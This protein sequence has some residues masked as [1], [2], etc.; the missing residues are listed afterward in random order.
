MR[1]VLIIIGFTAVSSVLLAA[2]VFQRESAELLWQQNA[3]IENIIKMFNYSLSKYLSQIA[4]ICESSELSCQEKI[5]EINRLLHLPA[6]EL[7]EG[8]RI[9]LGYYLSD[10]GEHVVLGSKKNRDIPVIIPEPGGILQLQTQP[11]EPSGGS[12]YSAPRCG[13]I[14]QVSP[15]YWGDRE[16]GQVFASF[17]ANTFTAR[18]I[19]SFP[20]LLIKVLLL[21][22][23][24]FSAVF[25]IT[26]TCR[27]YID[28]LTKNLKT[29][30]K[31]C[32]QWDGFPEINQN[33]PI[34]FSL[35]C[36]KYLQLA[37]QNWKLTRELSTSLNMA[38]MGEMIRAM[39]HDIRNLLA[40]I[41]ASA[42]IGKITKDSLKQAVMLENIIT[43]GD[44]IEDFLNR[45]L[46]LSRYSRDIKEEIELQEICNALLPVAKP[47]LSLKNI[48]LK[49]EVNEK[50]QK[51]KIY[52]DRLA[53]VQS[54]LNL[55]S[56]AVEA[57]PEGNQIKFSIYRE[58]QAVVISITDS[59]YGIPEE[60]RPRVF[61][62][63][64]T[65]KGKQ[66]VGLGLPLVKQM[67]ENQGG[68]IWFE[69]QVGQGATFF[70]KLPLPG[71]S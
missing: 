65:T 54:F 11:G 63:F 41:K 45:Y 39:A 17:P 20:R 32:L 24:G 26:K 42:E 6:Q 66:G 22:L 59:G 60:I 29:L 33:L 9:S 61:D 23:L 51:Q 52:G 8:T 31:T 35:P 68:T 50:L 28:Q 43:S 25:Y 10:I 37:R 49:V 18:L 55:F 58:R 30:E 16:L 34:E 3:E 69:S 47:M 1:I 36:E 2:E 46:N 56:N 71:E 40:V 19:S 14:Y 67:I 70:V 38:S 15:I 27:F 4:V 13:E 64:F 21:W 5:Q 62:H 44:T 12:M 57:T 48:S 53:L 7:V